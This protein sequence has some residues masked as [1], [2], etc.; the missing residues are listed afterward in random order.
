MSTVY[1]D[2]RF[3]STFFTTC[4]KVAINDDQANCP[5]CREEVN[6]RS[7]RG[8][9][10]KAMTPFRAKVGKSLPDYAPH[11]PVEAAKPWPITS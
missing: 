1:F 9:W 6:P 8:R 7:H 2:S 5:Q 11:R 3:N 4:C 10:E